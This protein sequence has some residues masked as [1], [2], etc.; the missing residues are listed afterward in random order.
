MKTPDISVV[1]CTFN[2]AAML[3]EALASLYDL[4]TD[5]R[6]TYEVL[7]VDNAS[8][9]PT[10]DVIAAAAAEARCPLRG[11]H[12]S[13]K[14]IVHAR[15]RGVEE[16]RGQWIAFFDDDQLADSRWLTELH[17]MADR[18]DCRAVGGA[19]HL[20]LPVDCQ[21]ELAPMC[22]ML[23][24]ESVWS[25]R[26]F[27][28]SKRIGPGA[29][30]LMLHR[31]VFDEIGSFDAAVGSRGED[32]ELFLRAH[33][34]GIEAWYVPTAIVLHVTPAERLETPFLLNL[35]RRMGVGIGRLELA[36]RSRVLF[37]ARWLAKGFRTALWQM[38]RWLATRALGAQEAALGRECQLA[39]AQGY[40]SIGWELLAGH[41][42]TKQQPAT[43]PEKLVPSTTAAKCEVSR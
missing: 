39:V 34:A 26:P 2:R 42:K 32:T 17:A 38:P 4:A 24:G 8:T 37:L 27:R 41:R 28:Y 20:K 7:V 25:D 15:N 1:V 33:A 10:A 40:A 13:R 3:R 31:S 11:V 6:F 29:G 5:E 14:G 35:A 22:R 12:E 21:R 19:V 18:K 16:A 23:L 36:E 30:N 9:D 43:L